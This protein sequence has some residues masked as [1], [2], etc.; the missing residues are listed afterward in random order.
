MLIK[1]SPEFKRYADELCSKLNS[2][3]IEISKTDTTKLIA[4]I[5]ESNGSKIV[6]ILLTATGRDRRRPKF[7]ISDE[8]ILPDRW[9][10]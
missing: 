2:A 4:L 3:G 7:E 9:T 6:I 1:A 8:P 10:I 5:G